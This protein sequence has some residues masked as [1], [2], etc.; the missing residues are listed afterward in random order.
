MKKRNMDEA[1]RQDSHGERYTE[2]M[3]ARRAVIHGRRQG[4]INIC[5]LYVRGSR[6][7]L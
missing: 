2:K 4:A 7:Q 6:E 1:D 5:L 3:K